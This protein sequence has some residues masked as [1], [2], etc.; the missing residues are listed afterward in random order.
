MSQSKKLFFF[1]FL[2]ICSTQTRSDNL[3]SI[4]QQ[5]LQSDPQLKTAEYKVQ[6]GNSQKGQALGQLLP[7]VSG[8]GNWSENNQV[9]YVAKGSNKSYSGTRYFVSLTQSVVDLAKFWAWRQSQ[10]I[11]NQYASELIEAQHVLLFN[12][13]Q[14][15]FGV[16]DAEDLLYVT[17]QEK[18]STENELEQVKRQFSKKLI[19]ITDLYEVEAR[20]DQ[21]KADEIEAES[22]LV[23]A[24]EGLKELTNNEHFNLEKLR[25]EIEYK[26]LE[27][28]LEDWISIAK[29]EN[30]LLAS[31]QSAIEAAKNNVAVQ[32]SR[33]LPV[34]DLQLNYNDS[35]T[36]YQSTQT[37][38][39][40]TEIAAL[41]V[42]V[43]IF[44]GGTT[45]HRM[46]EAQTRLDMSHEENEAKL[47]ALVKETSDAYTASN[48]NARR[49]KASIIAL[50][51]AT[52]SREAMQSG[53]KYGV[54]TAADLL[55]AQQAEYKSKR[56]LSRSKYAYIIN[57]MR[58]LKAIG[59]INEDNLVEVNTWLTSD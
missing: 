3:I 20:L 8:T 17:Q 37:P 58:F 5:A 22:L 35:N 28:K 19:K 15:Y 57:R 21:I 26:E 6:I 30:P 36:G 29:T 27:G 32:Q 47:R 46:H 49:I 13:V 51:S 10:E 55:R 25:D 50:R 11:E 24:K 7:Q 14:H 38:V 56:E 31:Q 2:L 45:T 39:Y 59:T 12:V 43:P 41:N 52:K 9:G 23:I 48:A 16:L 42:T 53:L 34:L 18:Q 40:Q 54:S 1:A 44:T 4:Y 33:Y